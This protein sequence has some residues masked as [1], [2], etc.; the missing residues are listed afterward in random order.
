MRGFQFPSSSN[1]DHYRARFDEQI[2]KPA[3]E[4]AIKLRC[5]PERYSWQWYEH[6][7][8]HAYPP[9]YKKNME[10]CNITDIQTHHRISTEKLRGLPDEAKIGKLLFVMY[11][12]L[13]R[14]GKDGCKDIQIEKAAIVIQCQRQSIA[15]EID[16]TGRT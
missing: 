11:P 16:I 7:N 6:R 14:C 1:W 10:R 13:F 2:A 9:V 8:R 5:S 12:G 15:V 4:L 3:A